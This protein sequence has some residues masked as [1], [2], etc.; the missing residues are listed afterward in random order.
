MVD[1]FQAAEKSL[2]LEGE[3]Y[4]SIYEEDQKPFDNK[5]PI[6]FMVVKVFGSRMETQNHAHYHSQL[7]QRFIQLYRTGVGLHER[8]VLLAVFDE[9]EIEANQI[10]EDFIDIELSEF[11]LAD[12]LVGSCHYFVYQNDQLGSDVC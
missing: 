12:D 10:N 7:I 3:V 1:H 5:C 11:G 8:D 4:I 6:Q 9:L 2:E